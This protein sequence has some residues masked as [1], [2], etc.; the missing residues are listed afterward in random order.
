MPHRDKADKSARQ[1]ERRAEGRIDAAGGTGEPGEPPASAELVPLVVTPLPLGTPADAL[2][3]LAEQVNAVRADQRAP[4][5]IRGRTVAYL[6]SVALNA[7]QARDLAARVEAIE[8]VLRLR[9][10]GRA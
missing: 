9:T 7:M 5:Q 6:V 10:E 1:R 4:A 3:I 8:R 2:A